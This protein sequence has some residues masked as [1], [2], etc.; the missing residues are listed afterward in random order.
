MPSKTVAIFLCTYNGQKYLEEQ[1]NSIRD[2]SYENWKIWVSD[3]GSVDETKKLLEAFQET[4][5][6]DRLQIFD[7]P[8]SGFAANFLSL[9]SNIDLSADYS[10]WSDQDDI[11]DKDKLGN[12]INWLERQPDTTPALYCSRTRLIDENGEEIGYSP[13]FRRP[14][15]F[16]NALVQSIAGGNTM[17]FNHQARSL[18]N[19]MPPDLE[20][21]SHDWFAYQLVTASGGRVY[22]D[23]K[24]TLNYRQHGA[25]LVGENRSL[26]ALFY[27]LF[28]LLGGRFHVWNEVNI[29][30]LKKMDALMTSDNKAILE[31]FEKAHSEGLISRM[32]GFFR[33]G[34]YRQTIVGNIALFIATILKKI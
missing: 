28:Q 13:L 6:H 8:R 32:S 11:W 7:G 12:A 14:P 21:I 26:K 4:V 25:N 18:F 33:S 31:H 34:I 29:K 23:P 5:G 30:A 27:R 10:A 2:Q 17:V 15:S 9:I 3:D 16:A 1:L 19:H 22:Y 20:I 24:A